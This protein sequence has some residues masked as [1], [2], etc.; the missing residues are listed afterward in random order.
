MTAD[1]RLAPIRSKVERAK[2]HLSDLEIARQRFMETNPYRI[3]RERDPQ[4]GYNIY[5]VFDIQI[6]PAD[7]GLITGDVIHNLRSVLDHLAYAL[8]IANGNTPNKQTAFPIYDAAAKYV[9]HSGRQIELMAQSA[10]DAINA[11]E[12]YQGGKGAGFWVLHYLDIADKHHALLTP[13]MNVTEASFSFPGWWSPSYRGVGGVSFPKFGEPLEDGD[14]V[15]TREAEMD[16][17]MNITL[18]VA[19]TEPE[20]IKG[21]AVVVTLRTLADLVDNLILSFK[22]LLG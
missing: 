19:F 20:V 14:I 7:I 18:D 17:D 11:N 5:R 21:R 4:T 16:D 13:L 8:V 1:E 10:I 15:A 12:P 2:Q 3:E 9:D 6:P 22:P